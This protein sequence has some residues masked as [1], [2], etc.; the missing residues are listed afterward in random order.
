MNEQPIEQRNCFFQRLSIKSLSL[1]GQ[2]AIGAVRFIISLLLQDVLPLRPTF[3]SDSWIIS[4]QVATNVSQSVGKKG[5]HSYVGRLDLDNASRRTNNLCK[6]QASFYQELQRKF[7]WLR[8]DV[9]SYVSRMQLSGMQEII[10]NLNV[11]QPRELNKRKVST[12]T[13]L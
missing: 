4:R 12:R 9:P 5:G 7:L 2:P 13:V 10:A 11:A 6:K 3:N 1:I 8:K